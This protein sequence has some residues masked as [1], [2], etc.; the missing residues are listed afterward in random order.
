LAD[1]PISKSIR[2][3]GEE[4]FTREILHIIRGKAA[5][6]EFEANLINEVRPTLNTKMVHC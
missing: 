5:A 6:F 1:Y 3:F 4:A 2:E